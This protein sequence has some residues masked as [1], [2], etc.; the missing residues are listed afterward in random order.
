MSFYGDSQVEWITSSIWSMQSYEP[1]HMRK[2]GMERGCHD[3]IYYD[4]FPFHDKI[5]YDP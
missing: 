3:K 5:C 1:S 4:P 2:N